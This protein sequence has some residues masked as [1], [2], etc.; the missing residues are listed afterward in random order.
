[1][2]IR[3]LGKIGKVGTQTR[4]ELKGCQDTGAGRETKAYGPTYLG[5]SG[6]ARGHQNLPHAVMEALH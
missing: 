6:R 4:K 1:M 3:I 5:E 2:E